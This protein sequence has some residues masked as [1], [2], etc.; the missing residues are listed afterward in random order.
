MNC[1]LWVH[2]LT[3]SVFIEKGPRK[4]MLQICKCYIE[5]VNITLDRWSIRSF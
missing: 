3:I 1:T 2:K 5:Q 4:Y